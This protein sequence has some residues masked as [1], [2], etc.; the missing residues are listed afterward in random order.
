MVMTEAREDEEE[1]MQEVDR[2]ASE[3]EGT[4]VCA[5]VCVWDG[6]E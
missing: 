1:Q 6:T 5:R 2:R 3:S 4:F